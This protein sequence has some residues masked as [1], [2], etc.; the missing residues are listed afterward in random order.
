MP[1]LVAPPNLQGVMVGRLA[2]DRPADLHDIDRYYY[3]EKSN[4]CVNRKELMEK[5]ISFLERVYPR[6][7]CDDDET[8]TLEMV[9]D[10]SHVIKPERQYCN[11]CQE[12]R[13]QKDY[14]TS[15]SIPQNTNHSAASTKSNTMDQTKQS[16][17]RARRHERYEGCKIVSR[18]IDRSLAPTH[19]ILNGVKG[20]K[21]F[22]QTAH[23]LSRDQAVRNCGPG[24]ILY[25]AMQ[26]VPAEVWNK[27]FELSGDVRS[28]YYPSK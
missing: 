27:T 24:F 25:K 1:P 18:I 22:L 11:I 19:S 6:R 23:K 21:S 26:S 16:G 15:D 4:P 5:Y 17:R 28:T 13:G 12:F 20:K 3:G 9:K 10:M 2:R 8:V 14:D 7:C